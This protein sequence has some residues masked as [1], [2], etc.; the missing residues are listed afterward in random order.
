MHPIVYIVYYEQYK[1]SGASKV[2]TRGA[3]TGDVA[4]G[5]WQAVGEARG[6]ATEDVAGLT[7]GRATVS[8]LPI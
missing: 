4:A 3:A 7:V 5:C 6:E 1:Q 2:M 8:C